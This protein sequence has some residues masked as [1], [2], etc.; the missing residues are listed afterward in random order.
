MTKEKLVVFVISEHEE[1]INEMFSDE[2][3]YE[4]LTSDPTQRYKSDSVTQAQ[5]GEQNAV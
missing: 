1:K 4:N 2:R 5:E 3:T